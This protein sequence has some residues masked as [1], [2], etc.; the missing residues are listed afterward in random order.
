MC[1]IDLLFATK[2]Q[3]KRSIYSAECTAM[4]TRISLPISDMLLLVTA[5]LRIQRGL[6]T[7]R[8]QYPLAAN[9][10]L[11]RLNRKMHDGGKRIA[12]VLKHNHV[13]VAT[14]AC[15]RGV[16]LGVLNQRLQVL[17]NNGII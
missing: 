13:C 4:T 12:R 17:E 16:I 7:R 14:F 1:S 8:H 15:Y 6:R 9:T 10:R 5:Y 3:I 2:E 11:D